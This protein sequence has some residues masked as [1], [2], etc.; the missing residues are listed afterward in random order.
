M[1]ILHLQ[2]RE[3][4]APS[5]ELESAAHIG[6]R[7]WSREANSESGS[8]RQ[9]SCPSSHW[10]SPPDAEASLCGPGDSYLA[11]EGRHVSLHW[12]VSSTRRVFVSSP[13]M[14]QELEWSPGQSKRPKDRLWSEVRKT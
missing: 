1:S 8:E 14:F 9:P 5:G 12:K 6:S 13:L 4:E 10:P 7:R 11:A 3:T 2:R